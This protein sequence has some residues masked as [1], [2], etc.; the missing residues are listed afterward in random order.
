MKWNKEQKKTVSTSLHDVRFETLFFVISFIALLLFI[1]SFINKEHCIY[2][3][4]FANYWFKYR[5]LNELFS[6]EP[7]TALGEIIVSIRHSEYNLFPVSLLL[8]TGLLFG[9]SRLSFVLGN[10]IVFNF[11]TVIL[12]A[13]FF[14]TRIHEQLKSDSS[15]FGFILA[16][17]CFGGFPQLWVPVLCGYLGAG[18]LFLAIWVLT[19]YSRRPLASQPYT[20]ILTMALLLSLMVVF[21]RWY[22]YWVVG[23]LFSITV[24]EF[25]LLAKT[26]RLHFREYFPVMVRLFML[27]GGSFG[28]FLLLATPQAIQMLTTDYGDIYSGYKTLSSF[29]DI[30]NTLNYFFGPLTLFT[31]GFGALFVLSHHTR[32]TK[33]AAVLFFQFWF[34]LILF[35]NT[36]NMG[37]H[38]NYILLP[39]LLFFACYFWTVLVTAVKNK[40]S[41]IVCLITVVFLLMVNFS[42]V[43]SPPVAK[44]LQKVDIVFPQLRYF[45]RNR[46]DLEEIQSILNY[47]DG[48]NLTKDDQVYVLASGYI[49]NDDILIKGCKTAKEQY[50][51]CD[52]LATSAHVDKRDG[53][54]L[55]IFQSKYIITTDPVQIHLAE[56]DQQVITILRTLL[57]NHDGFGHNFKKL[58]VEFKLEDNVRVLVYQRINKKFARK[59][60][61]D[62]S[63][64]FMTLYPSYREKFTIP[65]AFLKQITE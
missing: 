17:I 34:S 44:T 43:L 61:K 5:E 16:V 60:L 3:W 33:I 53:L 30:L 62:L 29:V 48:K 10:A 12:F 49:L 52:S 41:R 42:I 46:T 56:K 28:V 22:A 51:F 13:Y 21:R 25:I 57:I 39:S 59:D 26:Y 65:S 7:V 1:Y 19:I 40:M 47:I 31:A 38:H 23:F 64:I 45:P 37:Y 20:S 32:N 50:S 35:T 55:N 2:Y 15:R 8:P 18:G 27:G 24:V 58:D 4:D 9:N 36:Q 14:K 63:Q 6:S 54:P 11:P